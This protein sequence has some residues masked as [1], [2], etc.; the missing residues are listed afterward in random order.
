MNKTCCT[1]LDYTGSAGAQCAGPVSQPAEPLARP[2]A[3][4]YRIGAFFT[5]TLRPSM[6]ARAEQPSGWPVCPV[7]GTA[8]FARPA[9]T[10]RSFGDGSRLQ[11]WSL[12]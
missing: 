4:L 12:S 5:P 8:N 7:S 3:L 10:L 6:V 1:A 2:R 11:H 9:A